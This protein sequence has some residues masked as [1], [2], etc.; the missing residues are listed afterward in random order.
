MESYLHR[1]KE[2]QGKPADTSGVIDPI[3]KLLLERR[4]GTAV[5]MIKQQAEAAPDDFDLWLRYAEA[6]G[7]HC[8]NPAAAEK[9]ILQME[10]SGHFKKAQL[11]KAH[12]RLK[13]WHKQ[14]AV[15]HW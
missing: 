15:Q 1:V 8:G 11:R 12:N 14:H 9:I 3:E 13:K 5:E 4:L 6:H 7:H 2:A 10:R